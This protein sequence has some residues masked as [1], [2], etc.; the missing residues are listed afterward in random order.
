[1]SFPYDLTRRSCRRVFLLKDFCLRNTRSII[2]FILSNASTRMNISRIHNSVLFTPNIFYSYLK[3]PNHEKSSTYFF[4]T[5]LTKPEYYS[6]V[7]TF[8]AMAKISWWQ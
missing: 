7:N 3:T 6:T 2:T 8:H 1:M 5:V 4:R